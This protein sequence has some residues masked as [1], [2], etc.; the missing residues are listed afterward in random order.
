MRQAIWQIYLPT[1][2]Q[3][4]RPT[5]DVESPNAVHQAYLLFIPHDKLP[6]GKKVYQYA[7]MLVDV[8]SRFKAAE[9]PI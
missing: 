3:I 6:R 1:P 8:A 4:L 9:P 2:K 7:L 5:F